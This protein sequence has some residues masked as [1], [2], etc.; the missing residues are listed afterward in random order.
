MNVRAL[1]KEKGDEEKKHL[2][3]LHITEEGVELLGPT[4]GTYSRTASRGQNGDN[5][6]KKMMILMIVTMAIASVGCNGAFPRRW[7]FRGDACSSCATYET[8]TTQTGYPAGAFFGANL[9]DLPGPAGN[10]N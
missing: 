5:S 8:T 1:K 2:L 3:H 7:C 9:M 10:D 6:M 4:E